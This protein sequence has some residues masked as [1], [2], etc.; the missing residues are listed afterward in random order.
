MER[1]PRSAPAP[2]RVRALSPTRASGQARATAGR[3]VA[4][5]AALPAVDAPNRA[6][7]RASA[8][9]A[10]VRA[11][12]AA[13]RLLRAG[14]PAPW[15]VPASRARRAPRDRKSTRLNSSHLG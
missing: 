5:A 8:T 1:V 12:P 11:L 6:T 13:A 14:P 3:P 15:R 7:G 2:A 9:A 10:L 4:Q